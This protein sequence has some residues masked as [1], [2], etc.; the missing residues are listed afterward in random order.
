VVAVIYLVLAAG[1]LI[2]D[3]QRLPGLMRDGFLA[4]HAELRS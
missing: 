4:S 1:I 2:R 3:R